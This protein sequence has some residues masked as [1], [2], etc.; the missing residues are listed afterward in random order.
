MAKIPWYFAFGRMDDGEES[1][2]TCLIIAPTTDEI[3]KIAK[4]QGVYEFAPADEVEG[5]LLITYRGLGN[6]LRLWGYQNRDIETLKE[7]DKECGALR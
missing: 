3:K 1:G 7:I 4:K 5:A 6:G 2:K